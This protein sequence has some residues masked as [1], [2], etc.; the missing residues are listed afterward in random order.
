M[1]PMEERL[2][3]V[4]ALSAKAARESFD[5]Q[6]RSV[7]SSFTTYLI[8]KHAAFYPDVSQRELADR[9]GIEG[10]TLTRHLDRLVADGLVRRVRGDQDRRVSRVELTPDGKDHLG[11]VEEFVSR[12]DAEF[13]SMFTD[14]EIRT[15]YDLLN[16]IRSRY[17]RYPKEGHVEYAAD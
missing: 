12:V 6:L 4:L 3:R 8:L 14:V 1:E 2:G 5:E 13:R 9:L 15:L 17:E 7:G 11:G 10:P 16:R